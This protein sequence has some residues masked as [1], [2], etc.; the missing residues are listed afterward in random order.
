MFF[1]YGVNWF[2][3]FFG[4][5]AAAAITSGGTPLLTTRLVWLLGVILLPLSGLN[6]Y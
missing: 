6:D 1:L 4:I 3:F 2:D 5:L